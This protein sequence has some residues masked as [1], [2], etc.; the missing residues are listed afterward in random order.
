MSN[1]KICMPSIQIISKVVSIGNF[2]SFDINEY[3]E[4]K[5]KASNALKKFTHYK[6]MQGHYPGDKVFTNRNDFYLNIRKDSKNFKYKNNEVA[7]F[8]YFSNSL[9]TNEEFLNILNKKGIDLEVLYKYINSKYYNSK[10]F[11]EII[12]EATL[13]INKQYG[14]YYNNILNAIILPK[15][16]ISKLNEIKVY[17]KDIINKYM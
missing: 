8:L 4:I 9:C 2:E 10:Y 17:E 3:N 7:A 13:I 12:K 15:E 1:I 14:S 11:L 5:I 16:T 6:N